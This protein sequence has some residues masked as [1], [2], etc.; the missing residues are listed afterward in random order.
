MTRGAGGAGEAA[1]RRR[2]TASVA[3]RCVRMGSPAA[4]SPDAVSPG[5]VLL[6]VVP[7]AAAIGLAAANVPLWAHHPWPRTSLAVDE[8]VVV[9]MVTAALLFPLVFKT[10]W[11]TVACLAVTLP[12][13]AAAQLLAVAPPVP[14]AT[15]AA[16]VAVWCIGLHFWAV[17]Y[18]KSHLSSWMIVAVVIAAFPTLLIY[19][20]LEAA[21]TTEWVS[22]VPNPL[23]GVVAS[24]AG[25]GT[26]RGSWAA[27]PL[28][29]AAAGWWVERAVHRSRFSPHLA[30]PSRSNQPSQVR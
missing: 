14:T 5:G 7:Q 13:D 21:D 18:E 27:V 29:L 3:V 26:W 9:Q 15:A 16:W 8:L 19:A 1:R 25:G 28:P 4:V 10:L 11:T 20:G 6:W 2:A 17:A 30:P 24:A 23:A 12:F 22:A